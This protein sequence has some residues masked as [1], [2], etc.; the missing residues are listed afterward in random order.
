MSK[1]QKEG[2]DS[3]LDIVFEAETDMDRDRK[4]RLESIINAFPKY[5]R[6]AANNF[7]EN[8]N[9]KHE[10]M[11]HLLKIDGSWTPIH[12]ATTRDL[13]WILKKA[14]YRI[15]ETD[16]EAK[17][18]VKNEIINPLQVRKDCKNPK[19]RNIYF[20]LIHND[21]FTYKRM[22]KYKM[23][24]TPN[25]PRCNQIEMSKHLLWDCCETQK[26]WKSFNDILMGVKLENLKLTNYEDLF[27]I[28]EIPILM[29]IK[30]KLIQELIQIVRPMNWDIN[31]TTNLIIQ[32]RNVEMYNTERENINAQ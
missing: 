26:L 29:T 19:I 15:T 12:E 21:F 7:N 25:C 2:L 16:F 4:K 10:S 11:T 28:E 31:R 20:R 17:T 24:D 23:T 14:L 13:Q 27:R 6:N 30:L 32:L 1:F 22:L 18:E 3:F 9:T 5:F 8:L